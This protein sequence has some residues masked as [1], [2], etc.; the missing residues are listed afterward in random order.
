MNTGAASQLP[1]SL[2]LARRLETAVAESW[3]YQ[4]AIAVPE[5]F[6]PTCGSASHPPEVSLSSG[7]DGPHPP[8]P[9][10]QLTASTSATNGWK[11]VNSDQTTTAC[12]LGEV[13]TSILWM[14]KAPVAKVD[15]GCQP[16]R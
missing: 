9:S 13:A 16:P 3:R 14:P 11:L 15:A 12:P 10:E 7:I 1:A 4:T 5:A 6:I 2:R 8:P